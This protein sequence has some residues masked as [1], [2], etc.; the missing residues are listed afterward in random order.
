MRATRHMPP[1]LF[2]RR[3]QALLYTACSMQRYAWFTFAPWRAM[4]ARWRFR[5]ACKV[6]YVADVCRLSIRCRR[7]AAVALFWRHLMQQQRDARCLNVVR[8]RMLDY[9]MLSL[10]EW[11][12]ASLIFLVRVLA[13]RC[14]HPVAAAQL[15]RLEDEG[16]DTR[17][18]AAP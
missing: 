8:Q 7:I 13:E 5:R 11:R 16:N 14:R 1:V 12:K 3:P 15:R 4:L 9:P 17:V 2:F 10:C 6:R 18:A